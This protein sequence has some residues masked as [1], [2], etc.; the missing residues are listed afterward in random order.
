MSTVTTSKICAL[1]QFMMLKHLY[2]QINY[3]SVIYIVLK[4]FENKTRK[5]LGLLYLV[6]SKGEV[7]FIL[8]LI[9]ILLK[10]KFK[11]KN[12]FICKNILNYNL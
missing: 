7:C 9:K 8:F 10:K 3:A 4:C 1:P 2:L 11:Y 6:A 5:V 12:R